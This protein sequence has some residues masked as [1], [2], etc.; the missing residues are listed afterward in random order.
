DRLCPSLQAR[1]RTHD[2]TRGYGRA[3]MRIPRAKARARGPL[4]EGAALARRGLARAAR[5]H[6]P[7]AR[8]HAPVALSI[9]QRAT[10]RLRQRGPGWRGSRRDAIQSTP[11]L[12]RTVRGC[13][14]L[15][16]LA[17]AALSQP[18]PSSAR[19]SGARLWSPPLARSRGAATRWRAPA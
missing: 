19:V 11:H 10:T 14:Y 17:A 6:R 9:S 3:P 7:A 16:A 12:N 5:R 18:L 4:A 8:R 2:A 1:R 13:A 15:R